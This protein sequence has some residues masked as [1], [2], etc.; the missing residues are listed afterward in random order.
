[1]KNKNR[2]LIILICVCLVLASVVAATVLHRKSND[3]KSVSSKNSEETQTQY[4]TYNNKK[5]KQNSDV[6][7][8][9]FM[10]IDKEAKTELN[11]RPGENG[12]SDSLNLVVMNTKTKKAQ[13]LQISRDTMVDID[14][15]GVDGKKMMIEP[16]QIA[17]QYAYGDG[18]GKSCRLTSEKVSG[19]LY[20]VD[21]DM[22]LSLTMEGMV[23]ATDAIGGVELTIPEDYTDIDPNF[24]QGAEVT[25]DGEMAE[26]YVRSRNTDVLDSNNQRMERQSQFMGALIQKMQEIKGNAQYASLYQQLNPYMVTNMTADELKAVSEYEIS[27]EIKKV[28]GEVIEKDGHAQYIVDNDKL[29]QIVIEMFYKSL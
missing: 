15:Y 27:S 8:L 4:I 5:Y 17:L 28:P 6:K 3:K 11:N 22:Y 20:G 18:E 19:L 16:G 1:M 9:L 24:V 2:I 13:I 23:A 29:K 21:V 14:I 26:K 12:Q 25:L 10:G 7:T